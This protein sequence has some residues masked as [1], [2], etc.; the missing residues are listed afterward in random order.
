M[1][2]T[3]LL[4]FLTAFVFAPS[5]SAQTR[6]ITLHCYELDCSKCEKLA[7]Q[8]LTKPDQSNVFR[9]DDAAFAQLKEVA[10]SRSIFRHTQDLN[11]QCKST[12]ETEIGDLRFTIDIN[13]VS[14][15]SEGYTIDLHADLRKPAEI[16]KPSGVGKIFAASQPQGRE[17][18][19][20]SNRIL[21]SETQGTIMAGAIKTEN[22]VSIVRVF[23]LEINNPPEP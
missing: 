23:E 18:L 14:L 4:S 22:G 11:T 13:V 15:N 21:I 19:I 1:N 17:R 12:H 16:R 9:S 2:R 7:S 20:I 6:M 10:K 3:I 8:I 5:V